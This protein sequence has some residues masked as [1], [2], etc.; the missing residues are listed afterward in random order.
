VPDKVSLQL[1][2]AEAY[3]GA[4][5]TEKARA[6]YEQ[7]MKLD[8][9]PVVLNDIAYQLAEK[10]F[11]L[12]I[13]KTYAQ[14]TVDEEET[15]FATLQISQFKSSRFVPRTATRHLLGHPRVVYFRLNDLPA[16]EQYLTPAWQLSQKPLI[17]EHL[18][19]VYEREAKRAAALHTYRLARSAEPLRISRPGAFIP[20]PDNTGLDA[21]IKRLGG[22]PDSSLQGELSPEL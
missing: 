8:P 3:L 10:N 20:Q 9:S 15:E 21:D 19:R 4:G 17:G 7:A 18:G 11:D 2:L 14:K 22:T 1:G 13:A 16:A 12:N 6:A 5:D